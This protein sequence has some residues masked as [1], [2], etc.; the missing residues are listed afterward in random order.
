M[1]E[2]GY[3]KEVEIKEIGLKDKAFLALIVIVFFIG[4]ITIGAELIDNTPTNFKNKPGI[5]WE[6]TTMTI[7]HGENCD[8]SKMLDDRWQ[9]SGLRID[10]NETHIKFRRAINE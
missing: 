6:Y 9:L 2:T 1:K 7:S 10:K 4:I 5:Q 3:G 8:F